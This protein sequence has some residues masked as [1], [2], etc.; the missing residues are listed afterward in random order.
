MSDIAWTILGAAI[1]FVLMLT[2]VKSLLKMTRL[3]K[4]PTIYN[5]APTIYIRL[6]TV[7]FAADQCGF[8]PGTRVGCTDRV[9]CVCDETGCKWV[10]L[11]CQ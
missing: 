7:S 9:A 3:P 1:I 10:W 4:A 11:D 5:K 6:L 8:P 2:F